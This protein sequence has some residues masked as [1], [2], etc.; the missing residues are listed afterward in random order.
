MSWHGVL[1]SETARLSDDEVARMTG[2]VL[3]FGT[4]GQIGFPILFAVGFAAGDY[5]GAY[6]IITIPAMVAVVAMALA[7]PH[8]R[9]ETKQT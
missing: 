7:P 3:A 6:A 4:A 2:G 5:A 8:S 9:D 1:L